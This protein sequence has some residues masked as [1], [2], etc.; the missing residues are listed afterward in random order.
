MRITLTGDQI[1]SKLRT[2]VLNSRVQKEE[3]EMPRIKITK[4][5]IV[6]TDLELIVEVP[7]AGQENIVSTMKVTMPTSMFKEILA[8]FNEPYD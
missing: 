5:T 7:V 6:D 2:A 1:I 4:Y 8:E 3:R